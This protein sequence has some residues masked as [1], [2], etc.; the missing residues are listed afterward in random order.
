MRG[1]GEDTYGGASRQRGATV[2]QD[3]MLSMGPMTIETNFPTTGFKVLDR[4]NK[5]DRRKS[6][7]KEIKIKILMKRVKG[8]I[9]RRLSLT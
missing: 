2:S 7:L 3:L 6:I 9:K 4:N 5:E 8:P 1:Q